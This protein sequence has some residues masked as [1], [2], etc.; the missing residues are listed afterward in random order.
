MLGRHQADST[1]AQSVWQ[2]L[3]RGAERP[4]PGKGAN[5]FLRPRLDHRMM[6]GMLTPQSSPSSSYTSALPEA[7]VSLSPS[8]P[9]APAQNGC[10]GT[11]LHQ[12]L[13]CFLCSSGSAACGRHLALRMTCQ[14]PCWSRPERLPDVL[15]RLTSLEW[16]QYLRH[17]AAAQ[18]SDRGGSARQAW[19]G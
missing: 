3:M 10:T 8:E 4:F 12:A 16:A 5:T 1:Q 18:S 14:H 7:S 9:A 2:G 6:V 15:Q 13:F 17:W 19:R 11:Q